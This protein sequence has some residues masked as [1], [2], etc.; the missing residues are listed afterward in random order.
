MKRMAHNDGK[1]DLFHDLDQPVGVDA[2]LASHLP[3]RPRET[4]QECLNDRLSIRQLSTDDHFARVVNN[5]ELTVPLSQIHANGKHDS[6]PPQCLRGAYKTPA[7]RA[8]ISSI[9][10]RR[11]PFRTN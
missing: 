8:P 3:D 4:P 10:R 7:N 1:P 5:R 2:G 11:L 6:R 9:T